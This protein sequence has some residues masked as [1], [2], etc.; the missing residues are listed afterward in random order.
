LEVGTEDEMSERMR[1]GV[2]NTADLGH[3]RPTV[4]VFGTK[5]ELAE[6]LER[7]DADGIKVPASARIHKSEYDDRRTQQQSARKA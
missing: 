4:V 1:V 7:G 6:A 2:K 3:R 5:R